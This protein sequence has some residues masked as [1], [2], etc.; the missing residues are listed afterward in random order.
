MPTEFDLVLLG[1]NRDVILVVRGYCKT[2]LEEK[3]TVLKVWKNISRE[4][5]V[6]LRRTKTQ[7]CRVKCNCHKT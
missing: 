6:E 3:L 7:A 2:C 1:D 5:A 4:E